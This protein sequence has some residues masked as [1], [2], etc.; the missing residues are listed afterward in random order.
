MSF[1]TKL[2]T[3]YAKSLFQIVKSTKAEKKLKDFDF[4]KLTINSTEKYATNV[5]IIGE[6]LILIRTMLISSPL[7]KSTF[8]NPTYAEKQKLNI[9]F[10][11]FPGL[12]LSMKS[13]LQIL[14]ERSNLSLLPQISDEYQKI[15]L[16]F[17]KATKLKIILSS[18]IAES[19]GETLLK[20]LKKITKSDEIFLSL[21]YN[22]KLLGGL[23]I[24]YNSLALDSSILKEFSLFLSE[25]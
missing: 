9:I 7:L 20:G 1:N 8:N 23:I 15:L 10:S 21:S 2:I 18:P 14:S 12:T 5:S 25:I 19:F 6:E 24:E 4:S 3:T 17:K 22:P 11:V 16:K 13:F